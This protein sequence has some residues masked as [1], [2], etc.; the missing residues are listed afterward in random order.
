MDYFGEKSVLYVY[1]NSYYEFKS[2]F[3]ETKGTVY[4]GLYGRNLYKHVFIG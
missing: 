4:E 2:R 1:E 3:E